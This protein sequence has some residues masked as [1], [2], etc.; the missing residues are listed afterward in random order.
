MGSQATTIT[1]YALLIG[2]SAYPSIPLRGCVRDVQ[3]IEAHLKSVLG[4]AVET[5]L[6]TAG[7]PDEQA[8]LDASNSRAAWPSRDNVVSAFSEI[9]ARA[10]AGDFVYVHFSGHGTRKPP[11]GEFSNA[12]TGDLALALLYED[13]STITETYLW[14]FELAGLL[15]AMVDRKLVVT[16]ALDCCFSGSVYRSDGIKDNEAIRFLP[17]DEAIAVRDGGEILFPGTTTNYPASRDVYSLLNW[18][19]DPDRYAILAACGPH[20]IA[21]NPKIN[22]QHHGLFSYFLLEAIKS[23]GLSAS[24]IEIYHYLLSNMRVSGVRRQSPWRAGNSSQAF[25]G[26]ARQDR[27]IAAAGLVPV[28]RVQ[29][30]TL[31]LQAGDAHGACDGD[32]FI[33][34]DFSS[35]GIVPP[36]SQAE[37]STVY[38][39]TRTRALTSDLEPQD[40][41]VAAVPLGNEGGR[42]GLRPYEVA[43][44][45]SWTLA[46]KI[47]HLR[48]FHSWKTGDTASSANRGMK[49]RYLLTQEPI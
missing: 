43:R 32:E 18:F 36:P 41:S 21:K 47:S 17:Y 8:E 37:Q 40:P 2:I 22:G 3:H 23:L 20:E 35:A 31:E 38:R 16:L 28:V 10:K 26:H 39:I 5:H 1:H 46:T 19:I 33:L 29:D 45:A 6:I 34:H 9:T 25:F 12:S 13:E 24:H 11:S 49:S 14:G 27:R 44:F 42:N 4:D 30:G 15:K 48:W 7:Q